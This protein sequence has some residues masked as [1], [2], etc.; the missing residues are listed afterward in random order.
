MPHVDRIGPD[1][2]QE[3]RIT[4]LMVGLPGSPVV[5]RVRQAFAERGAF[6][7]AAVPEM[8]LATNGFAA[9]ESVTGAEVAAARIH[10]VTVVTDG[11]GKLPSD[12]WPF[13]YLRAPVIPALNARGMAWVGGISLAILLAFAPP[14]SVRPSGRMFF[15]GAGF[16][17]LETKGVVHMALVF[18]STWMVNSLVFAA[19]LVMILLGNLFVLATRPRA[20]WP[21][22]ACLAGS[23]GLNAVVPMSSFLHLPGPLPALAA[24]GVVFVPVFF[25]GVIFA[26]SLRDGARP[27]TALGSNVAG[28]IL[29]GLAENLSLMIG[30]N[31]LLLV[32][33]GL[34]AL[35]GVFDRRG[36]HTAGMLPRSA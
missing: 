30:F 4:C 18:G 21:H 1:D 22:Y 15:L 7:L 27:D 28:V 9:A 6:R 13:L 25:A 32:A 20:L 23:L 14:R 36:V 35:S 5:E 16:M 3:G 2:N 33:L 8:G 19:I 34:Y 17:L 12:D 10:P 29:G 31:H 11:V 24:C 26:V